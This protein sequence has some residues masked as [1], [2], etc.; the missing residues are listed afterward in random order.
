MMSSIGPSIG[1]DHGSAVSDRY[2]TPLPFAGDLQR[3]DI[4]L[5]SN[6]PTAEATDADE[7]ATMSRQ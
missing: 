5:L 1:F 7:R 6:R 4:Q 2:V 3:I